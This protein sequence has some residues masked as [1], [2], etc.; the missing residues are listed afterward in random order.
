M[1]GISDRE[2]E[3]VGTLTDDCR[4]IE[5]ANYLPLKRIIRGL[6]GEQLIVKFR[7]FYDKRSDRQNR[8]FHGVVIP[9][10]RAWYKETT[11]NSLTINQAKDFVY[12]ELLG[13]EPIP[14]TIFGKEYF[15]FEFKRMSSMNTKEFT[16]AVELIRDK[17]AEVGCLI[18]EPKRNNLMTDYV[19]E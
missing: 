4:Y 15:S 10:I 5:I 2:F 18:P 9:C 7:K 12:R 17:M 13:A 6:I 3:V 16:D 1:A 8:Y 14:Y 11:G 19:D